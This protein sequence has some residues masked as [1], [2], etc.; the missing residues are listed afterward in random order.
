MIQVG[1]DAEQSFD[2]NLADACKLVLRA[3]DADTGKGIPGVSFETENA[4]AEQ[5]GNAILGDNLGTARDEKVRNERTDQ[6]GY[7]VRYIGPRPGY[8]YFGWEP[9][10]YE[11]VAPF[12]VELKTPLGTEKVEHVFKYRK[13]K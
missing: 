1:T 10:G 9:K 3:V 5:W 13:K 6:D 11:V 4:L 2:F 12:E 7:F 8:T